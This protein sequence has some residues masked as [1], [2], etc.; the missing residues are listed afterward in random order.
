MSLC[1]G[2]AKGPLRACICSLYKSSSICGLLYGS[3]RQG[4]PSGPL[5]EKSRPPRYS[6]HPCQPPRESQR[7]PCMVLSC[8]S[9]NIICDVS[10]SLNNFRRSSALCRGVTVLVFGIRDCGSRMTRGWRCVGLSC[11]YIS[12]VERKRTSEGKP[13]VCCAS[14]R[15]AGLIARQKQSVN[16]STGERTTESVR[17][18][19]WLHSITRF[20]Y[21]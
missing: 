21:C 18:G 16:S 11:L 17:Q 12:N 19:N 7:T 8:P 20:D 10:H 13:A 5:F 4:G 15:V 2:I 1:V 3:S 6:R 9:V 14:S